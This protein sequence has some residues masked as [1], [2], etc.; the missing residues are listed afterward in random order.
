MGQRQCL[1]PAQPSVADT[2][3]Y[4]T[5]SFS[6][7]SFL[8]SAETESEFWMLQPESMDLMRMTAEKKGT[9]TIGGQGAP[10]ACHR[11]KVRPSGPLAFL[12]GA[13]YWFRVEDLVFVRYESV[14]G[15]PGSSKTVIWL[16]E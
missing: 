16:L 5:L 15:P 14:H 3:W 4:Q 8:S 13:D 11:V 2:P 9:E 12:W 6:L 1:A 7:R 10:T